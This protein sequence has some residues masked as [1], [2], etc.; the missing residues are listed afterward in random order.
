MSEYADPG[1]LLHTAMGQYATL[2]VYHIADDPL[3]P[4]DMPNAGATLRDIF[5]DLLERLEEDFAEE[6]AGLDL[7]PLDEA[8]AAFEAAAE[9]IAGVAAL[10][11]ES[12][13]EAVNAK[14]R[15]F[16]RGFV[17]AGLLPGRYSYYNVVSAPGLESGYGADIFPAIL[18]CLDA[19]DLELAKEWV[20]KSAAAVLRSAEILAI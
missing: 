12:M 4:W 16:A 9:R 18:D 5:E 20:E 6:S 19:G 13:L 14:Y 3:I 8:V 15:D 11:D 1:F 7:G 17:S 2:L 10:G